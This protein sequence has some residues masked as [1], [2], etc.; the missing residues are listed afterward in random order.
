MARYRDYASL[1]QHIREMLV[2]VTSDDDAAERFAYAP[3]KHLKGRSVM[4]VINVW[5]GRR[6]VE[7][8]LLDL[9]NYLGVDDMERFEQHFGRKK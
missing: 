7:R 4:E 8:F 6:F 1:P 9:G 5:F 3:N 2:A